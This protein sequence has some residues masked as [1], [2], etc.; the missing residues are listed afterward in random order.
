ML[1]ITVTLVIIQNRILRN[2]SY[3]TVSGKGARP[4]RLELGA[5]R[6][7]LA[8]LGFLYV[9]LVVI[10]PFAALVLVALRTNIFFFSIRGLFNPAQFGWDQIMSTVSD[11]VVMLSL[12]NSLLVSFGTV[13]IGSCLY[14]VI[15]YITTRTRIPGRRWL[16]LIAMLPLALPG[17]I[18]GL[19]YLWTWISVP[20]GVY[21]TLWVIILAY[22]SQFSPQGVRAISNSLVQIHPELEESS[23]VCGASFLYSLRRIVVP[24]SWPGIQS[25]MV[26]LLIFSFREMS[27]ALFLYTA[28]TQVFSVTM[29]DYWGQGTTGSVAV[30]ALTQTV[31]LSIVI[32]VGKR[33]GRSENLNAAASTV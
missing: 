26:L 18:I 22:V 2:R 16:D 32:I 33:F 9:I 1:A 19:G 25:G 12:K 31:L 28:S 3:V 8:M 11:P 29:F 13:I 4:K 20:V 14:F 15:A 10:L 23:R 5:S 27:T 24:L 30:M 7:P 17:L 6:W 21:G